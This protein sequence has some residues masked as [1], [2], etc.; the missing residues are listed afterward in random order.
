MPYF[1]RKLAKETAPWP[2]VK[3]LGILEFVGGITFGGIFLAPFVYSQYWYKT[4]TGL[5][6]VNF[7]QLSDGD[8][9]FDPGKSREKTKNFLNILQSD[10]KPG[11]HY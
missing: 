1:F 2:Q 10:V 11:D 4:R 6:A 5:S 7:V 3:R 8:D 9:I